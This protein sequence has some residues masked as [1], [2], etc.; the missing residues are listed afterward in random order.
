MD[1]TTHVQSFLEF[2]GSVSC[3]RCDFVNKGFLA[4]SRMPG[5]V[6]TTLP[7]EGVTDDR[8]VSPDCRVADM[9]LGSH[10]MS[11]VAILAQS[12]DSLVGDSGHVY[13][14]GD[15]AGGPYICY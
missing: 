13:W 5:W 12:E 14:G 8:V 6:P 3:S 4:L 2:S 10:F 1:T 11:G 7:G 15:D 9:C